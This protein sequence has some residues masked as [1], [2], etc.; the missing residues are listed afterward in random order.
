MIRLLLEH[1]FS[2]FCL[3]FWWL[4]SGLIILTT[5][6]AQNVTAVQ[7][8]KTYTTAIDTSAR[9]WLWEISG[10]KLKKPSYLMGTIHLV[11]AEH[12]AWPAQFEAKFKAS[13]QLILEVDMDDP[14]LIF[15]TMIGSQMK[16]D[17]TIDQLLSAAD[18]A[19]VDSF[20]K[21]KLE[22]DI[23]MF[24]SWKPMLLQTIL[25]QDE[26]T[27]KPTKSVEMELV[28]LAKEKQ[29]EV[30][31][32]ETIE[33]QFAIFDKIPYTEQANYLLEAI[34]DGDKSMTEFETI[35]KIYTEKN[36]NAAAAVMNTDTKF[37]KYEDLLMGNRNKNWIDKI[38]NYTKQKPSF[39][40]VGAAHLGGENGVLNL[41]QK[42]GYTI[43]P[44][45]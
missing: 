38:K 11:W 18:F 7:T 39:F 15:A 37:G 32:L 2:L 28:Q 36:V 42:A 1:V 24:K 3:V 43:K 6:E 27:N 33:E 17:T 22:M 9:T 10:K 16:N 35:M 41:L 26:K 21:N 23:A 29:K 13:K 4:I 34:K 44:V 14:G 8:P 5:A 31:G 19:L 25:L 40:A 30:L 45:L 12:F 20:F